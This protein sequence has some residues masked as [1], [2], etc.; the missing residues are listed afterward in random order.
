MHHLMNK[1]LEP[2]KTPTDYPPRIGDVEIEDPVN[3]GV[4]VEF[5]S[6]KIGRYSSLNINTVVYS[7]VTIG[8]FT[9][10]GRNCQIGCA[11]HSLHYLSVGNLPIAGLAL[12]PE[13]PDMQRINNVAVTLPPWRKRGTQTIIGNDAWI[14]TN[15]TILQG[16]T[17]GDG[18][19]VGAG[20][21][22]VKDV[23][24]YAVVAGNPAKLLKYRFDDDVI[25]GLLAVQWWN[26]PIAE[27]A[28]LPFHDVRKCIELLRAPGNLDEIT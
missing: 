22:V 21:V 18:A 8:R 7:D 14:A 20:A 13:D 2:L 24:A 10:I 6:G 16:V 12:F 5:H 28:N 19:V 9:A 3:F 23:P 4:G 17:I 26:R 15:V 11:D 1:Q 25:A 27:L